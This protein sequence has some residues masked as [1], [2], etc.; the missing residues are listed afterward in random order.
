MPTT[1]CGSRHGYSHSGSMSRLAGAL[2]GLATLLATWS[3]SAQDQNAALF[4][5][6]RQGTDL[7]LATAP[8]LDFI[9]IELLG[10]LWRM[11]VSGGA[12]TPLTPADLTVRHPRLNRAG[13]TVVFQRLGESGWD[14][15][16]LDL[17][18]GQQTAVTSAPWNEREP[19]FLPNNTGIVFASDRSGQYDLW[20][21]D[22]PGA[23]WRLV[24]TEPGDA[25][26]PAVAENAAL[27]YVVEDG[28]TY[29]LRTRAAGLTRTI[30]E[31]TNTLGAPG[32]RPGGG[33]I[34]FQERNSATGA[35]LRMAILSPDLLIRDLSTGEDLFA[36]RIGWLDSASFLYAADGQIWRRQ[37]AGRSRRPVHL[38]ATAMIAPL[39]R[40]RTS[41]ELRSSLPG[42][43]Q[44][45]STRDGA[46]TVFAAA[47]DIWLYRDD[48]PA[49]LTNDDYW[50]EDPLIDGEGRFV[51]FARNQGGE[52][53][54]WRLPLDGR[55]AAAALTPPR[56]R[57]FAA[58]LD[59]TGSRLAWLTSEDGFSE[60]APAR[61]N[62]LYLDDGTRRA[63]AAT[64]R[65]LAPPR[66]LT[67]NRLAAVS[68]NT[69]QSDGSSRTIA[70]DA[71]LQRVEDFVPASQ[72]N[73]AG[74]GAIVPPNLPEIVNTRASRGADQRYV[75]QA[76]RLFDGIGTGYR[77]HVDIHVESG[78]IA[79]V[80]ARGRLPLPVTVID[81]TE[82]TVLPGF[83]DL[84]AHDTGLLGELAGRAWLAYGVTTVRSLGP[85]TTSQ[86]AIAAAWSSGLLPGPR[87]IEAQHSPA[88]DAGA[89]LPLQP[90]PLIDDP[91]V[92]LPGETPTIDFLES[93][94]PPLQP[95][96]LA[97][98]PRRFSPGYVHYQDVFALLAASGAT[99]ITSLGVFA[100]AATSQIIDGNAAERR[101]FEELFSAGDRAA[102]R[103]ARPL[104]DGIAAR[105][106]ALTRLLRAGGTVA[107]GA[108]SPH[109]PPGLGVHIE[110]RLFA[111]AG[112]PN[113]QVLR[114]ATSGAALALGLEAEIGTVESGRR[115]DLVI[116]AGDPLSEIADALA[117]RAVVHD[118]E[119][120]ER[121]AL[122]SPAAA[123]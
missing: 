102:W 114:S 71:T 19:D 110:L 36:S 26:Y 48:E 83:I 50:N 87:F 88:T 7:S 80:V 68:L 116:V 14:I 94:L 35:Q 81:A 9:V 46:A 45:S 101:A 105:Q 59:S 72:P 108:E 123:Q 37:L 49:K 31:T 25:R 4:V 111:A 122:I 5:D 113:D 115:A 32:W 44:T 24:S 16:T 107:V 106:Q 95:N 98:L 27:V 67:D 100:P 12:A 120:T 90:P 74:P 38:F 79:A 77:R 42:I 86:R 65:A 82:L 91:F 1:Q 10:R 96:G 62:T 21:V 2:I 47:G 85:H 70:F 15:W 118:G 11:P 58:A 57:A 109:T 69:L 93:L 55:S 13:D 56:V 34:V 6:V 8:D 29:S 97:A 52:R 39:Q 61:L 60:S 112:V 17:A 22:S 99:E 104:V 92:T 33:V 121:A 78:R 84:H 73:V 63:S 43:L 40:P 76:G 20:S 117:I 64:L 53:R 28:D 30:Y 103:T 51:I 119:W 66:W 89:S 3:A 41:L 75:I 23:Q 18:T 54:L